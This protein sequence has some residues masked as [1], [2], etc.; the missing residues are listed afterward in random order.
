MP[1][2]KGKPRKPTAPTAE[3]PPEP[4]SPT[5]ETV[6]TDAPPTDGGKWWENVRAEKD[7]PA[8][9]GL[10]AAPSDL[11]SVSSLLA[12]AVAMAHDKAADVTKWDGWRLPES[13]KSWWAE[14]F[15][16]LL[17]DMDLKNAPIVI[18]AAM[19][20]MS[21]G[22]RVAMYLSWRKEMGLGPLRRRKRI[23]P[24][25]LKEETPA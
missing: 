21:E 8:Q 4:A 11:K 7:S 10:S 23:I 9:V 19:L 20:V 24:P 2:P 16:Y 13:E 18:L 15:A 12:G 22:S 1:W 3:T 6:E 14:C 25:E 17:R 5:V